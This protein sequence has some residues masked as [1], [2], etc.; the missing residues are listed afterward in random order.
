VTNSDADLVARCKSGDVDA[1]ET[2]YRQHAPRVY[3]LACR[4]SGSSVEGEDLLQEIFLLAHQR[5]STFRGEAS[6]GSWLYRLAMNRCLDYV[7]GRQMKMARMTDRLE[8]DTSK[9]PAARFD[10]LTERMDLDRA[11]QSL[12]SG[13]REAFVLHDVEGF[14]HGEISEMLGIAEGTSKSQVAKARMKLRALLQP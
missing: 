9:E 3:S 7:R 6:V 14:G 1:F 4:L 12:P 8:S 10:T 5:L 11:I 13:C 2:L